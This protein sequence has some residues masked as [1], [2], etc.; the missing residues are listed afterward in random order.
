MERKKSKQSI[1]FPTF[2]DMD[3]FLGPPE[4]RTQRK[5][6]GAAKES[7]NLY[8]LR[9]VLLHK[10]TSAYHGHYEAQVFDVQCVCFRCHACA[11]I[12][13]YIGRIGI[14]LGISSTTKRSQ[15]LSRW[16]PSLTPRRRLARVRRIPRSSSRLYK[17]L[18]NGDANVAIG[19]TEMATR[20]FERHQ[21]ND[22]AW[23]TVTARLKSSSMH[24]RHNL[25]IT[26]LIVVLYRSPPQT[27]SGEKSSAHEGPE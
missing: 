22:D 9:G 21:R 8:E 25:L 16:Y 11:S 5:K 26:F 19:R 6:R 20:R 4:H 15:R 17:I 13:E 27:Q 10:G 3:R 23:R 1:L 2:I 7:K 24:E 18:Q 14:S 12:A